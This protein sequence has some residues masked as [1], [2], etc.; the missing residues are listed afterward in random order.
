MARGDLDEG[1]I[2][3]GAQTFYYKTKFNRSGWRAP[4][5]YHHAGEQQGQTK[6]HF[7]NIFM[8]TYETRQL[9]VF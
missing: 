3:T 9:Y 4:P 6:A 8:C 7:I 2:W 1:N 5:K